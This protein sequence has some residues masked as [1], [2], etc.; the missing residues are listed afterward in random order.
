[1]IQ[2]I[3]FANIP[4]A[5]VSGD[6]AYVQLFEPTASIFEKEGNGHIIASFGEEAGNIPYTVFMTKEGTI[7]NN[8]DMIERFTTAIYKAQQWVNEVDASEVA[9]AIAPYFDD[10]EMDIIEQSVIRYREQSSFAETPL[11]EEEAWDNLLDIMNE[12][13][14]LQ[15]NAPYETLVNQ[16][17]ANKVIENE[18]DE[19]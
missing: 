12:A 9:T 6:A 2:N 3:E 18:K 14:E 7:Q 8:Q 5:F 1:L 15:T 17:I 13:G 16:E 19:N 10:V 4:G 11:L